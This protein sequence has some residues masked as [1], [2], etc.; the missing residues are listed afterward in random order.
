MANCVLSEIHLG[1]N[2]TLDESSWPSL[3]TNSQV[4]T[5]PS[6]PHA[7]PRGKFCL[8]VATQLRKAAQKLAEDDVIAKD[9]QELAEA[10]AHEDCGPPGLRLLKD[11]IATRRIEDLVKTLFAKAPG[12]LYKLRDEAC[13]ELR[14]LARE[15]PENKDLIGG[16]GGVEALL[17][18]MRASS[19]KGEAQIGPISTLEN[20]T[21]RHAKNCK[22]LLKLGGPEMLL[23]AMEKHL[24]EPQVQ[25]MG[26]RLLLNAAMCSQKSQEQV[27]SL[28]G[29]EAVIRAMAAHT[30]VASIQEVGCRTLKEF[31]AFS[32]TNQEKVGAAGG[33][34]A[35]LRAMDNHMDDPRIQEFA[36]G[37][38]RNMCSS[39]KEY[40]DCVA[41]REGIELV[42]QGMKSHP[43]VAAVQW[44]GCWALFCLG[45]HNLDIQKEIVT[46]HGVEAITQTMDLHRSDSKVQESA[47]WALRDLIEHAASSKEASS[48]VS[49]V[50][51][52]IL[53][54]MEKHAKSTKVQT[55]AKA[56][57]HKLS[58]HDT[59]GWV[60]TSILGRCGRMGRSTTM[61]ALS[62]IQEDIEE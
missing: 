5:A 50:L 13:K 2:S 3:Q 53:R 43:E 23:Q 39:N 46:R 60:K 27:V 30:T 41:G 11:S 8:D 26:S 1:V 62:A 38:L 56:V 6:T 7:T 36:C 20:I 9:A 24:E 34:P 19:D 44:A 52:P 16:L 54:A 14:Q 37:V 31:A 32:S 55:A 21:A 51:P 12:S 4:S 18:A 57:L 22:L 40:Q 15:C 33:L 59:K 25:H 45:V 49:S 17:F 29:I 28:G 58:V 10:N 48:S 42:L 35:V 47:C 61:R